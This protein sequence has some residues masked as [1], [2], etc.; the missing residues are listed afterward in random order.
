MRFRQKW[1][2]SSLRQDSKAGRWRVINKS[3]RSRGRNQSELCEAFIEPLDRSLLRRNFA[4]Q[5]RSRIHPLAECGRPEHTMTRRVV[6]IL[7]GM[8]PEATILLQQRV[9][10]KVQADDD[11]DHLPL[12]I[13]MNPQVP[14]RIAHL[15]AG[16]DDSPGPVLAEM[17]RRLEIAGA[18]ALGMPCNTAHH[19]AADIEDAVSVPLLNMVELTMAQA[20]LNLGNGASLGILASPAARLA[21]VFDTAQARAD[22]Q[23]L[24]PEDSDQMLNAIRIIKSGGPAQA[25]RKIL[26]DVADE[27]AGRGATRMIVAC[28]ELSLI[29]DALPATV[30]VID[31][32]DVLAN[33][34]HDH[35]MT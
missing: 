5:Q 32:L 12:L 11:D 6:G 17:A 28:S 15:I 4:F 14:S 20:A 21:G 24:W 1:L 22:L 34:I 30:Q 18:T 19:Y 3:I 23:V 10:A 16:A 13:D 25:A 33:A 2:K 7:G 35:V 27:L 29:V 31:T 26:S 9:L 8:G